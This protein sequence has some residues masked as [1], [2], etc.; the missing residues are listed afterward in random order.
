MEEGVVRCDSC[1]KIVASIRASRQVFDVYRD[2]GER[3]CKIECAE[4][5]PSV[6]KTEY[7]RTV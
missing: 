4:C 6:L 2:E 5:R 7:E 3:F 1:K